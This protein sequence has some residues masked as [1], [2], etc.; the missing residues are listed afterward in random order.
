MCQ[1]PSQNNT[2][3][4]MG[5]K[6]CFTSISQIS[7]PIHPSVSPKW[8]L[9][10]PGCLQPKEVFEVP[11][12]LMWLT[13][14]LQKETQISSGRHTENMGSSSWTGKQGTNCL[15]TGRDGREKPFSL[16]VSP[17]LWA[18]DN[19]SFS[20]SLCERLKLFWNKAS[21]WWLF[22]SC[23]CFR[24]CIIFTGCRKYNKLRYFYIYK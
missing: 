13:D 14:Q 3:V 8:G 24:W 20:V 22:F 10:T 23:L 6:R 18:Q 9:N 19:G 12:D 21:L 4:H 2:Q 5:W 15:G 16:T 11:T 17:V 1:I 7:L